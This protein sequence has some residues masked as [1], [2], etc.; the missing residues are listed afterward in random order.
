MENALYEELNRLKEE[1]A[2]LDSVNRGLERK[3]K[4]KESLIKSLKVANEQKDEFI[5]QLSIQN[6]NA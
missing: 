6:H 2:L 1:N 5:K 3:L 4:E